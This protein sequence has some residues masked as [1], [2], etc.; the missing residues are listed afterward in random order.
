MD[1]REFAS[2]LKSIRLATGMSQ[3]D[4]AARIDRSV[5]A[6]SAIERGKSFP[7]YETLT[8]LAGVFGLTV[9][10]LLKEEGDEVPLERAQLLADI[11]VKLKGASDKQLKLLRDLIE[12]ALKNTNQSD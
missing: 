10:E 1:K 7:N 6:L 5:D 9:P 4:L 12:A 2:H 3:E 8:R 11:S